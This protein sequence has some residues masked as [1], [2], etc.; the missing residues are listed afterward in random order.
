MTTINVQ[1]VQ[2]DLRGYLR[3]VAAGETL[4]IVDDDKP[5]AELRPVPAV[6]RQPRPFGLCTGEFTVPE[7]FDDPLPVDILDSFEGR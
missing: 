6:S 3:R 4:L 5:L 1:E 2:S 7:G